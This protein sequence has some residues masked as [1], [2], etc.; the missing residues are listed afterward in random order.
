MSIFIPKAL[1]FCILIIPI[2][3]QD[4]PPGESSL[5][6]NILNLS[7]SIYFSGA[8]DSQK[9][10][11]CAENAYCSDS[12]GGSFACTCLTNF[13]GSNSNPKS[14]CHGAVFEHIS[15]FYNECT[16]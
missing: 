7:P 16:I 5:I 8:V 12:G 10:G 4:L 15:H 6:M 2:Y 1:Y 9:C 3:N 13:N 14:K 11:G